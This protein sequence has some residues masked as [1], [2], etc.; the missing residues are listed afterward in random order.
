[1]INAYSFYWNESYSQQVAC[2]YNQDIS[3]AKKGNTLLTIAPVPD[4]S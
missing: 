3:L 2:V 4:S 1:M